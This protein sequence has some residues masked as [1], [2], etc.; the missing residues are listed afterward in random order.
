MELR[1]RGVRYTSHSPKNKGNLM[2]TDR[3][4]Y[5]IAFDRNTI[6]FPLCQ[7]IK[8]LFYRDSSKIFFHPAKFW[9][10]YKVSKLESLWQLDFR[11]E[12]FEFCWH[13]EAKL[14]KNSCELIGNDRQK[15]QS[16]QLKYRGITYYR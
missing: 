3:Q 11:V 13:L 8:Q 2:P 9:H 6:K 4:S 10:Q 15:S 1:Y 12:L 7:Y 5:S 14:D 16:I